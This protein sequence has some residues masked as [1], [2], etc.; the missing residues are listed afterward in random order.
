MISYTSFSFFVLYFGITFLI[1][2]IMPP[3]A[4]WCV[5]L[6]G[7]YVFY[8]I[9]S[10][11]HILP[12]ILSSII[13]W[14]VGLLL[15]HLD[16]SFKE[17]RKLVEKEERKALKAKYKTYKCA[18]MFVGVIATLSMLL[19]TKYS[20]FFI[21]ST[22]S[23]FGSSIDEV[24]II[25]PL[26]ISFFTLQAISYIVD[27][28][29]G[30]IEAERNPLRVS[31][32]LSFMLSVVEGPIARY[33][34]LGIQLNAGKQNNYEGV[35]K[36][37]TRV[38]W[39]L[40]KKVVIADRAVIFVASVFDNYENYSG[41]AII[42]GIMLYTL[43]LYCEFSGIM[44]VMCG[45]GNMLGLEL[46]ENFARPFFAKTINEFWQRWHI[47]LGTW[48]KDYIFYP[49]SFSKGIK[50][51]SGK[52][53]E[54]LNPYYAKL[55]P[56]SIALFFVWFANGFWHGA[57]WKYISYGL[58]YYILM[59]IGMFFEPFLK[60]LCN[61]L[62]INRISK[63]YKLFQILRTFIIVN[64]G[65]LIFRAKDLGVAIK[66]LKSIFTGFDLSII[67]TNQ[68]NG[69][70]LSLYDYGAI[71]LGFI[72]V[73][74]VGIIQENGIDIKDKIFKLP[75]FIKMPLILVFVFIIIIFGAY[76]EGYGV[77]DLIYA[78]F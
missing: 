10:K 28:Y 21:T 57:D 13:V 30:R 1:Y 15:N 36:G 3:K 34:Q 67:S 6:G 44:D 9:S 20:N 54:K 46:P 55:I 75:Y 35:S 27:V 12:L 65:M 19:I 56:T 74:S 23:I 25:Q 32:F 26:G 48:L 38:L 78:N 68:N 45:L 60:K 72:I 69:F 76:G 61:A 51:I 8:F 58:Y 77:V 39:G 33:G 70:G 18:I 40:F 64:I 59:M 2:S 49:I 71:I 37:F 47:S 7:S 50:N 42:A 24:S 29:Y 53:R 11:G 52:T 73:L 4:K 5:L 41:V 16:K 14:G 17:K 62:K 66:M 63:P 22:N 31:L 43:Q